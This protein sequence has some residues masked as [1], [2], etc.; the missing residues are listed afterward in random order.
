MI[1]HLQY[2]DDWSTKLSASNNGIL[3]ANDGYY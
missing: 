2:A 3:S 1:I